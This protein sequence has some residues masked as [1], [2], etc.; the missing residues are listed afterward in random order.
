MSY[1]FEKELEPIE[2]QDPKYI[3]RFVALPVENFY[4]EDRERMEEQGE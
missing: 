4:T 3:K 1:D 2:P